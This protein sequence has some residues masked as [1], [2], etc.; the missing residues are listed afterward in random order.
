MT[1]YAHYNPVDGVIQG[2]YTKELHGDNIPLP[3]VALTEEQW[4]AA[5]ESPHIVK[6]G[7]LVPAPPPAPHV[8]TKP[9]RIAALTLEY[10]PKFEAL[11]KARV[12]VQASGWG[13]EE[14]AKVDTE[15]RALLTEFNAKMEAIMND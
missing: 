5:L 2:F 10:E 14:V 8:P 9:E 3:N 13:D 12:S 11:R 6:D 15:Y 4:R 7:A 1:C